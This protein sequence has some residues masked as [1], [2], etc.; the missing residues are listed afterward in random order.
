[1]QNQLK[2]KEFVDVGGF[3]YLRVLGKV[4]VFFCGF[5]INQFLRMRKLYR[6]YMVSFR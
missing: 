4:Y 1:M 3:E 5:G 2:V 6:I